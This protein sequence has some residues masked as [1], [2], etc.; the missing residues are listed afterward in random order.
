MILGGSNHCKI[1]GFDALALARGGGASHFL[2]KT[3]AKIRGK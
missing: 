2:V 1:I 3:P